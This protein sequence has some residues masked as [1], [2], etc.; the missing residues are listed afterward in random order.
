MTQEQMDADPFLFNV[1]NGT[2]DLRTG[3]LRPH[4]REDAITALAPVEHDP[5]ARSDLFERFL[6]RVFRCDQDLIRFVQRWLGYCLTADIREQLMPIFFGCGANG[7]SVFLDTVTAIMGDY[8]CPAP[9]TLLVQAQRQ[10]HPTEIAD[11]W[12]KRLVVASETEQGA[13][14]KIQLLK[15]LTGD[16][17]LKGRFMNQN[18]FTFRR[19]HKMIMLTNNKPRV[20]E[21]SEAVW[22]RLRLTPFD[23]VIPQSERDPRL[24]EK[25]RAEAPAVLAWM[26]KGCLDW[27]R[28]GLGNSD[29]VSRATSCYRQSE[30]TFG[31]FI[32]DRCV[33]AEPGTADFKRLFAPWSAVTSVYREW[34]REVGLPEVRDDEL[35]ALL[36][37]RGYYSEQRR[38][39]GKTCKGRIGIGLQTDRHGEEVDPFIPV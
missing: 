26:V 10:E 5:S 9:P 18:F 25:L 7:K 24:M 2:I 30:D 38:F 14:L 11:L 13:T 21:D 1:L 23:V 34:A 37:G 32:D 33:T 3:E 28:E 19:T 8:A 17:D 4:R 27:Q 16:Q 35:R 29:A 15:R 20:P 36:D 39:N 31:R 22:R 12:N 6:S